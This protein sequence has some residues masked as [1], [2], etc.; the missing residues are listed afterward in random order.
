MALRSFRIGLFLAGFATAEIRNHTTPAKEL[1]H[2]KYIRVVSEADSP[3]QQVYIKTK[4]GLYVAAALRKPKGNGPF[5]ALIYF[6]GAP[7]GRGM[8]QLAG[9]SRGATGGPLWERFLQEGYVVVVSDYR[10]GDVRRAIAPFAPGAIT[11]VDDGQAVVDYV[12]ALPYVDASRISAYG[13]SL[14]GNLLSHLIGRTKLHAAVLGAPAAIGFL[15]VAASAAAPGA[16]PM[17]RWKDAQVDEELAAQNIAPIETPVLIL[18]GTADGLIHI[19]RLLHDRLAKAGKQVWMEVYEG[20]YHDFCV[21]PQGHAGRREP[22]LDAT[23]DA[24]ERT[25]RFLRRP[26]QY[27]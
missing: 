19:D 11:Y 10:G 6:H 8:E 17:E 23:L 24:L 14:G 2:E 4:D 3:V 9:W 25:V 12:R 22:L 20:G 5:P 26:A 13:V 27:Q 21:G 16:N 18:V 7:G 1:P 15:G